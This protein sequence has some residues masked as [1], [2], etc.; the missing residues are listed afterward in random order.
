MS[1]SDTEYA[2]RLRYADYDGYPCVFNLHSAWVQFQPP[3][4]KEIHPADAFTKA[5]VLA[6]ERYDRRF[7]NPGLPPAFRQPYGS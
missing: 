2:K 3:E 7:D 1:E 4:W 6:K 5:G